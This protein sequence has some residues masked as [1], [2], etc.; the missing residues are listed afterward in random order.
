VWRHKIGMVT[1]AM[2]RVRVVVVLLNMISERLY[3]RS[4]VGRKRSV[5]WRCNKVE[6]RAGAHSC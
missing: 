2:L 3:R 5:A 4:V 1:V 6:Q